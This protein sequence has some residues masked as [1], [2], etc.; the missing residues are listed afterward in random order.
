MIAPVVLELGSHSLKVHFQTPADGI[1]QDLRFPWSLG[2][3]VYDS[4]NLSE[5]T[6]GQAVDVLGKLLRQ[7]F[8]RKAFFTIATGAL[9][10][11]GNC[12]KLTVKL[13]D[14]LGIQVR[15][16]TG[17]EEASLLAEGY[18]K[19]ERKVPALLADIGGGTLEIVS[20]SQEK[21]IL[22]DSLP[23]GAVRLHQMGKEPAKAWNKAV[24]ESWIKSCFDEAILLAAKEVHATG[25]TLRGISKVLG[26][27][28][29]T[30]S[31]MEKLIARVEREGPPAELD[32]P[33]QMVF[34]PG[35]LVLRGLLRHA[36]ATLLHYT[37]VSVG[38]TFL[39]RVLSLLGAGAGRRDRDE[40]LKNMRLTNVL[41]PEK[42][43]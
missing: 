1:F 32:A 37:K 30:L 28:T 38:R 16:L 27:D 19:S 18:L 15:V 35:L 12:E 6:L 26:K 17:R 13:S 9:R 36:D 22:R 24:V 34:L 5:E 4:G 39:E 33:R 25:G 8:E 42:E 21:T 23:L 7:G 41:Y 40:L 2:H 31:E 3:E 11:A 10:D 29:C 14:L 43:G 20:L